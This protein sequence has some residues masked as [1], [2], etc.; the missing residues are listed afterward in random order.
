ME[1]KVDLS[2]I[3]KVLRKNI[4][5]LITIPVIFMI[6]SAI[7][8]SLFVTPKYAASTQILVNQKQIE[9]NVVNP[10]N[11]QN[12]LQSVNTYAEIIKSPRILERV[13]KEL[14]YKYDVKE[15]SSFV[16]V[17]NQ[18][19]SQII[20]VSIVTENAKV[21]AKI[22]NKVAKVFAKEVP[23][24][25]D[26]DNVSVLSKASDTENKVAPNITNNML[27]TGLAAL[28]LTLLIIYLKHI[29]DRRIKTEQ[30]VLDE[31]QLPVL[32][33]IQKFKV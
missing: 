30:D 9:N 25:M 21:S 29:L 12:S 3:F 17:T 32:G 6:L 31:L 10:N 33:V 24:I 22:A 23:D 2:R 4:K 8:T 14:D 5:K 26:V 15:L 28:G 19:N 16:K 18:S 1:G 11:V 13:S 27:L 20:N 7:F